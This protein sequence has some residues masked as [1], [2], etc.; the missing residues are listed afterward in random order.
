MHIDRS[1]D[2]LGRIVLPLEFCRKLNIQ[3]G[4]KVSLRLV[5][6]RIVITP[7]TTTC[8]LCGTCTDTPMKRIGELRFCPACVERLHKL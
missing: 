5:Q 6:N 8:S 2:E 1:V 7:R 3:P 4:N